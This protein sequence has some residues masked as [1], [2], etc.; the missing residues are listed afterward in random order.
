MSCA[1]WVFIIQFR[2][3]WEKAANGLRLVMVNLKKQSGELTD[4]GYHLISGGFG[5]NQHK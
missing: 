4:G 3:L 5:I 2:S 1:F